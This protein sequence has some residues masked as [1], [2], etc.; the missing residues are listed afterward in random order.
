MQAKDCQTNFDE[1]CPYIEIIFCCILFIIVY[2]AA[3]TFL[4]SELLR[5]DVKQVEGYEYPTSGYPIKPKLKASVSAPTEAQKRRSCA[6]QYQ[7]T[8]MASALVYEARSASYEGAAAVGYVILNR[9]K[10]PRWGNTVS[11]V[12]SAKKRGVCQFS[13]QCKKQKSIPRD[14]DWKRAYVI[15]YDVLHGIAQNPVGEADHYHTVK[16]SPKWS[17]HMEYV[18]TIDNHEFYKE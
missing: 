10:T 4:Y 5:P 17:R 7:C 14:S 18:A 3:T 9:V 11:E 13:Y 6:R 12:I 1:K 2:M 16:V 15:A 8:A